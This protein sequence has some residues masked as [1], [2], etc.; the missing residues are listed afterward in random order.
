MLNPVGAKPVVTKPNA[1]IVINE[2]L[3]EEPELE[4]PQTAKSQA[5]NAGNAEHDDL[6]GDFQNKVKKYV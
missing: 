5:T 1:R 3:D 4:R 6:F 2:N